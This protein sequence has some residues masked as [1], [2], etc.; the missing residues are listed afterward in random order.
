VNLRMRAWRGT[1]LVR[2]FPKDFDA[3]QQAILQLYEYRDW[4]TFRQAIPAIFL[5]FIPADAFWWPEYR[6]D[7]AAKQVTV[8]SFAGSDSS[9][10][11]RLSELA[12]R[13]LLNHP[14]TQ[15]FLKGC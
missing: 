8:L 4:E 1:S 6:V 9:L 5:K 15:Y 14:S 11:E 13:Q 3:L 7:L 12:P 2:L 10:L